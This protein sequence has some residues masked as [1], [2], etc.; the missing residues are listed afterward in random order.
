MTK[1]KVFTIIVT[2]NGMQWINKCIQSVIDSSYNS[3]IIVIDN[4]STDGTSEFIKSNFISVNLISEK[5]NLGFGKANNIGLRMALKDDADFVLLLNQ[6]AYLKSTTLQQLVDAVASGEN[7]ADIISPVHLSNKGEIDFGFA[8]HI[9]RYANQKAQK[10]INER[11]G[12]IVEVGFVNAACWL[13][14]RETIE[15]VGGFNPVFPHY[16]ED[17]DYINR[18]KFFDLKLKVDTKSEVIHD[19]I[20]RHNSKS[21]I[22]LLNREKVAFTKHLT[23]VNNTLSK[24]MIISLDKLFRESIYYLFKLKL[25]IVAALFLSYFNTLFSLPNILSSRNQSKKRGAYL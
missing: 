11:N 20:Q 14:S 22:K 4:C 15:T 2:Y 21:F 10:A 1:P 13:L 9:K 5:E 12:Q 19:R 23:N 3:E 17:N 24:G 6:D 7:K 18:L 8:D 25:N 16:G